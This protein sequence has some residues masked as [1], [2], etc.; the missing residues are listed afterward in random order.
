MN[1]LAPWLPVEPLRG[2]PLRQASWRAPVCI[3]TKSYKYIYS[4]IFFVI[5][6]IKV[7][8]TRVLNEIA[9]VTHAY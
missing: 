3:S 4:F 6:L 2:A 8:G 5:C 9:N 1:P 7:I